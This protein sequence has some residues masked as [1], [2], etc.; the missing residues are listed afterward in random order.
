MRLSRSSLCV[1]LLWGA[2]WPAH[3]AY[4]QDDAVSST[5]CCIDM[6]FPVGA[7][8]VALGDAVTA[9][10]GQDA[11]FINPAGLS[12]FTKHQL[13]AHRSTLADAS[14]TTLGGL[15]AMKDI[16][17]FGLSYHLIDFGEQEAIDPDG[18]RGTF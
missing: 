4:A 14:R 8:S 16:G 11:I 17:V 13:N 10:P 5:E 15:F 1:L 7:R 9:R 12:V 3:K 6:L 2:F 18:N